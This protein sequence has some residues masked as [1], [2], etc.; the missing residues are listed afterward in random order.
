M[1]ISFG[2]SLDL[3]VVRRLVEFGAWISSGSHHASILAVTAAVS[4]Q[5][6]CEHVDL[7]WVDLAKSGKSNLFVLSA[8]LSSDRHRG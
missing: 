5:Y 8:E 4:D 2:L 6:N 1:V 7:L 3:F